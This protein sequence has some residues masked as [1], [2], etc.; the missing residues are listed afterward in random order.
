M[1]G[2]RNLMALATVG[3]AANSGCLAIVVAEQAAK[4]GL[5]SDA[6]MYGLAGIRRRMVTL[7]GR[8]IVQSL[9]WP[10][11]VVIG[12]VGRCD[13]VE[14]SQAQAEEVIESFPLHVGDPGLDEAVG[15]GRRDRCEYGSVG[16]YVL[17]ETKTFRLPR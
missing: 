8:A 15:D 7:A 3:L 17:G 10:E 13:V 12:G 16:W 6:S 11:F 2:E 1:V 4:P 5:T 14:L 9:V